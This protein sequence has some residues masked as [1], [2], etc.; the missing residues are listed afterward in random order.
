MSRTE[1][2]VGFLASAP[3][4]ALFVITLGVGLTRAVIVKA[5]KPVQKDEVENVVPQ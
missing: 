4:V 2:I 1:L 3:P 5:V